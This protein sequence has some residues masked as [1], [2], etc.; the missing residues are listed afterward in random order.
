MDKTVRFSDE[1]TIIIIPYEDRKGDWMTMAL[2]RCRFKRRIDHT[3]KI[4]NPVLLKHLEN[5]SSVKQY[6]VCGQCQNVKTTKPQST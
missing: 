1:V 4:I 6:H 2:D 3:A 5:V